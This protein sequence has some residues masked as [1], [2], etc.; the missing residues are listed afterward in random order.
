MT[1]CGLSRGMVAGPVAGGSGVLPRRGGPTCPPIRGQSH[2]IAPTQNTAVRVPC[3]RQDPRA[4]G[5]R[6]CVTSV[7][8]DRLESKG[9]FTMNKRS[10]LGLFLINL[11]LAGV[12]FAAGDDATPGADG[13][14]AANTT[15]PGGAFWCVREA[16]GEEGVL[17]C[18]TSSYTRARKKKPTHD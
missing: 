18:L 9:A 5:D 10:V 12:A 8:Y 13:R 17:D 3:R 1:E 14:R 11:L 15:V 16:L 2:R 7:R 6:K 4:A